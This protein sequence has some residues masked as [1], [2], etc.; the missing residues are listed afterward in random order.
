M[1]KK[2]IKNTI[3][4]IAIALVIA[5]FFMADRFLKMLSL[6][7]GGLKSITLWQDIFY[8]NLVRNK[9]IAFSLPLSGPWLNLAI[10]LILIVI[11]FCLSR[12]LFDQ[13]LKKLEIVSLSLVFLG[14]AS[15]LFD[16]IAYGYV[17][18]YLELKYFTIF[19][20]ADCL[21]SA[22]VLLLIIKNFKPNK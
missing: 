10:A 1:T 18:D 6:Q 22:G 8:F 4:N 19:N 12:L 7:I 11:L 14:A 2:P 5:I 20:L 9:Y 21:I 17:I 15:N 13:K 16:R 3:I